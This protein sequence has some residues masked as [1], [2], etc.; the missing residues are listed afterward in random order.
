MRRAGVVASGVALAL[1]LAATGAAVGLPGMAGIAADSAEAGTET[2]LLPDRS[3]PTLPTRETVTV[4][5]TTD[6]E[7]GTD[8]QLRLESENGSTP[9]I[10]TESA[11]VRENGTFAT[12]F[13][14][15]PVEAN[16]TA[17]LSAYRDGRELANRS[18][19]I[20]HV[21]TNGSAERESGTTLDYDG[22]RLTVDNAA[23]QTISGTTDR[24]PGT[25]LRVRVRSTGESPFLKQQ[26][27]TV[28]SDGRFAVTMDF[29]SVPAG[30]TFQVTVVAEDERLV[31]ATG[32]VA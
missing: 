11:T 14:L 25:E 1:A 17:T 16:T 7:S 28:G 13:D 10:F 6:L 8:I 4:D 5:G 23:G 31:T 21:A 32:D 3:A 29:S 26:T 9:F 19:R 27:T 12:E 15:S 22:D 18:V 24:E 2:V 20:R 30:A